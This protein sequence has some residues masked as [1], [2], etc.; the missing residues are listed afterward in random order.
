M[1]ASRMVS[2]GLTVKVRPLGSRRTWRSAGAGIWVTGFL[3]CD[4]RPRR[5]PG[6]GTGPEFYP[7][8][9]G[10]ALAPELPVDD[11]AVPAGMRVG[12]HG[13]GNAP[14]QQQQGERHEVGDD[15]GE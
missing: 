5:G 13:P 2:P 4:R 6:R 12:V 3:L 14:R 10:L 8:G 7:K 1:A 15:A 9:V 11:I